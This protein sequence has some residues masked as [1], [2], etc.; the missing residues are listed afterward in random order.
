[1][2]NNNNTSI[3]KD[4]D[5]DKDSISTNE[6][7]DEGLGMLWETRETLNVCQECK[8][9]Y[10][11][12]SWCHPCNSKRFKNNFKNWTSNNKNIDKLIQDNQI[13]A[14]TSDIL[15]WIPYE[16]FRDIT[17]LDKGGFGIVYKATWIDGHITLYDYIFKDWDRFG[18]ETV[19][20]KSL[21]NSKDISSSFLR[22]IQNH[23][24]MLELGN[25]VIK[26]VGITQNPNTQDY[27]IVFGW[28]KDGSLRTFMNKNPKTF[29]LKRKIKIFSAIANGL[30]SLHENNLLHKDFHIGNILMSQGQ[31]VIS[32]LGLCQPPNEEYKEGEKNKVYGVLPYVAPEVLKGKEYSK[33]SD[34]YGFGIIMIEVL[35]ELP[36]YHNRAHNSEL[37]FEICK[38]ERPQIPRETPQV[39]KEIIL[40]CIDSNPENRPTAKELKEIFHHWK[41][42]LS[43]NTKIKFPNDEEKLIINNIRYAQKLFKNSNPQFEKQNSHP[44]AYYTSRLLNFNNLPEPENVTQ[45]FSEPL[46]FTIP[47]DVEYEEGIVIF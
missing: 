41:E 20:L 3:K 18:K 10:T 17:Y 42:L 24:K 40:R 37:A 1:M 22:E 33:A 43:K 15:E 34:I 4:D 28:A 46:E 36:P 6:E 35:S 16:R 39:L 8:Q 12:F 23:V 30:A 47:D 31:A 25:C 11:N 21:N 27:M 9:G 2:E 14:K 29:T 32:D 19:V 7:S 38:G 13:N 26:I 5:D 44:Q 45:E